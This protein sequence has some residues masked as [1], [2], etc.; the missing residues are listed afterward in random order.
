[1]LETSDVV[2]FFV[3]LVM[4]YFLMPYWKRLSVRGIDDFKILERVGKVTYPAKFDYEKNSKNIGLN[5]FTLGAV[6]IFIV[7]NNKEF[8]EKM[9]RLLLVAGIRRI[10]AL[11]IFMVSKLITGILLFFAALI[12][13]TRNDAG[14]SIWLSIFLSFITAIVGG[15]GL[16]NM[17][18][19]LLA[20]E[21]KKAIRNG[22]P[23]FIDLLVI[24][25]E[26]GLNLN[27][28]VKRIAKEMKISHPILAEELQLTSIE[29]EMA[30]DYKQV[31]EN[32]ENRVDCAEIKTLSRTFSQSIA[33]GSSLNA[34]LRDLSI[35]SR[36]QRMLSAE[37]KATRVPTMLTIP[38][39]LFTV[40]CLFI[41]MLGPVLVGMLKAF[42]RI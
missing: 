42:S 13:F 4:I 39:I 3:S 30:L 31:F 15:H 21:R 19:Q 2:C 17:Y 25:F 36:Q 24:C 33:Y 20:D 16:T 7:E 5:S 35:S 29:L 9:R 23:D 34:S 14:T 12:F 28:A 8:I 22:I 1:M 26:S 41:I 11:E 32:L 37:T 40:P 18:L 27:R 10:D 38:M 6:F